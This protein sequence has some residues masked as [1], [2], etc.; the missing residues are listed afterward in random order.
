M[1]KPTVGR[2]VWVRCCPLLFIADD[3]GPVNRW[4]EDQPFRGNIDFVNSD[5]N[6]NVSGADHV[7]RPFRL[8]SCPLV[9]E[10]ETSPASGPYAEWMPYQQGQA[11]AQTNAGLIPEA[12][13]STK[14]VEDAG[15]QVAVAERA[16][17]ST[18]PVTT[19][20]KAAAAGL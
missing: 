15:G 2:V 11:K 5:R 18:P 13:Q 1:I 7:G 3:G 20:Q 17:V 16:S 19:A 8:V 14:R 10:G 9:Q 6:I 12:L 4:S